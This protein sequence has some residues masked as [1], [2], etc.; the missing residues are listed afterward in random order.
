[1]G[2]LGWIILGLIVGALVRN[3]FPGRAHGGWF[4]SLL[5]GVVGA[6]VGGWLGSL[7]F[8][9]GVADLL[10]LRT[11]V[12]SIIGAVLVAGIHGAIRQRRA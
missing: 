10:N 8:N 1:M 6:V 12:P 11:W 5:L 3:I 2:L 7:V 4:A 9:T